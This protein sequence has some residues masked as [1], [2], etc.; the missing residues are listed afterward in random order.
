MLEVPDADVFNCTHDVKP[1]YMT[2]CSS[3]SKK[4]TT[5]RKTF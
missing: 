5:M 1:I 3:K 2:N 4:A